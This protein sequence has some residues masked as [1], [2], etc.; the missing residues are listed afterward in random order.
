MRITHILAIAA[1]AIILSVSAK[2]ASAAFW[3]LGELSVGGPTTLLGADRVP[4]TTNWTSSIINGV[5]PAHTA[6]T[7]TYEFDGD[8][9]KQSSLTGTSS[10]FFMGNDITG[11]PALYSGSSESI[12]Y[13]STPDVTDSSTHLMNGVPYAP[14]IP[15]VIAAA[16]LD[17]SGGAGVGSGTITITNNSAGLANFFNVF[18]GKVMGSDKYRVTYNVSS[19]PLPAALPMFGL[20]L[21]ALR[22]FFVKK[23]TAA[24]TA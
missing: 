8:L 10:Y 20:A 23:N 18:F 24:V 16:Q 2:P 4:G 12:A 19:V 17:S 6:V 13:G 21:L 22:R 15:P 7:F 11:A 9:K 5:L 14:S 1:V 3:G